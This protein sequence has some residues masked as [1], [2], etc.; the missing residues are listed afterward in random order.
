METNPGK[1]QPA[2]YKLFP[3]KMDHTTAVAIKVTLHLDIYVTP[4]KPYLEILIV[5]FR[6]LIVPALR[7]NAHLAI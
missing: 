4:S 2:D 1:K 5:D 6:R 7:L 3:G